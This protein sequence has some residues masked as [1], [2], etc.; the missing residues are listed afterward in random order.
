[1][2]PKTASCEELKR[3]DSCIQFGLVTPCNV[4]FWL[5]ATD[6]PMGSGFDA[7][8]IPGLKASI[9]IGVFELALI[10]VTFRLFACQ[11]RVRICG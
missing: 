2:R 11:L 6:C 8:P 4:S 10:L 7:G 3:N 5:T 1:M 9:H